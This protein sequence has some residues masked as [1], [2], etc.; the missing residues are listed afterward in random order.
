MTT[1][2]RRRYTVTL[3]TTEP[4]LDLRDEIS[5]AIMDADNESIVQGTVEN[6]GGETKVT[7]EE[8]A[9]ELDATEVGFASMS[10]EEFAE[11]QK[12]DE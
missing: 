7:E 1:L 4:G 5:E 10:E 8:A 9:R 2:F 3:Y 11:L 6:D 12:D